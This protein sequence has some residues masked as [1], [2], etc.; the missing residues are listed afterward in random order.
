MDLVLMFFC[1]VSLEAIFLIIAGTFHQPADLTVVLGNSEVFSY[2]PLLSFHLFPRWDRGCRD[3]RCII[4]K[5]PWYWP[6]PVPG[7]QMVTVTTTIFLKQL[8][9]THWQHV[10]PQL[11]WC[12]SDFG[13]PPSSIGIQL[14][15]FAGSARTPCPRVVYCE[16]QLIR[17]NC[18]P[19]HSLH[20]AFHC[21]QSSF[22]SFWIFACNSLSFS[23]LLFPG[24]VSHMMN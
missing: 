4:I 11:M 3:Q 10:H 19:S 8:I 17:S 1:V 16:I 18:G 23:S 22:F 9:A 15:E 5:G 7:L 14:A 12:I 24:L 13:N 2:K 20:Q 21:S 6:L